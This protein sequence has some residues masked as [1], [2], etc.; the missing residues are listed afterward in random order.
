MLKDITPPQ[1][2]IILMQKVKALQQ[3]EILPMQ[4]D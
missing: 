2:E 3:L 4:W 1:A